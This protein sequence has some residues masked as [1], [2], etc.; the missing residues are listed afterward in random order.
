MECNVEKIEAVH[1]NWENRKAEHWFNGDGLQNDVVQS[2]PNVLA[3]GTLKI[4]LR[5]TK[6]SGKQI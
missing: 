1:V 4:I 3:Q 6:C 2:D 5:Y